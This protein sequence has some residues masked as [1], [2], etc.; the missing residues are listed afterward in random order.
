MNVSDYILLFAENF[1]SHDIHKD[2]IGDLPEIVY[3][4]V[5]SKVRFKPDKANIISIAQSYPH[6][7]EDLF[8]TYSR[9]VGVTT[10]L[11]QLETGSMYTIPSLREAAKEVAQKKIVPYVV[12]HIDNYQGELFEYE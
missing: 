11:N 12:K 1:L 3:K 8:Y 9:I 4:L 2:A 10:L 6:L 5:V 7:V